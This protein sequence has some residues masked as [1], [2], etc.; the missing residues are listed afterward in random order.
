MKY[1][2]TTTAA[3]AA[4]LSDRYTETEWEQVLGR[5]VVVA[6]CDGDRLAGLAHAH[7]NGP[8]WWIEQSYIDPAYRRQGV[9]T[10]MRVRLYKL[11]ASLGAVTTRGIVTGPSRRFW[12]HLPGTRISRALIGTRRL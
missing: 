6:V 10:E 12:E 2:T 1:H 9:G 3:E 11:L 8:D 7:G 4:A 5:S